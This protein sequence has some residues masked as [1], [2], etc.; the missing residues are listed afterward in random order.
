MASKWWCGAGVGG[1]TNEY[2][3]YHYNLSE[4]AG[5]GRAGART[6]ITL[7]LHPVYVGTE[8]RSG[9]DPSLCFYLK[10]LL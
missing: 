4:Q 3:I 9:A 7:Y 6:V 8:P 2:S 1:L 5:P 10:L